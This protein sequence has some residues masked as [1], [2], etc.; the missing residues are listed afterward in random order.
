MFKAKVLPFFDYGY[1]IHDNGLQ[2]RK[3][4]VITKHVG[5]KDARPSSCWCCVNRHGLV[6]WGLTNLS[7]SQGHSKA[8]K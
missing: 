8:V 6:Y 4:T 2:I 3:T 7:N 5:F 1:I